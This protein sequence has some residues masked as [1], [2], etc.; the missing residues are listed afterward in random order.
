[1]RQDKSTQIIEKAKSLGASMAGIASVNLG[2]TS[3]SHKLH[4]KIRMGKDDLG[5]SMSMTDLNEI[6]WPENA[7]S[8]LVIA[9]SHP[10][11]KPELDWFLE[12]GNTPGNWLLQKINRELSVWIEEKYGIKTHKMPYWI[13]EGGV[14]LKDLAALSG[15]G[16][17]GKNNLLITPELGPRVRFRAML[18]EDKLTPTGPIDFDPCEGCE[19]FCRKVCPL[20]VFD[21]VVVSQSETG[22]S[23]LPGR[24]GCFSRVKCFIRSGRNVEDSGITVYE[25]FWSEMKSSGRKMEGTYQTQKHIIFCRRCELACTAGN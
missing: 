17:I 9:V 19:E 12:S 10:L 13:Q 18:L 8:V 11:S 2:K 3:P 24:D 25:D 6:K 16:C 1:M 23:S 7:M 14:Y 15:L 4:E 22:I 20:N 21:E 5:S